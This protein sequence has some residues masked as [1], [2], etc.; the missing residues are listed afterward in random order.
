MVAL[1]AKRQSDSGSISSV[2]ALGI[3]GL[4]VR[5]AGKKG[6]DDYSIAYGLKS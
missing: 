1:A 5:Y 6:I 3:C 4:V 2:E